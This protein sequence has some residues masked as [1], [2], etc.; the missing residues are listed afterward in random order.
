ML[1][2]PIKKPDAAKMFYDRI[3]LDQR[4]RSETFA[5]LVVQF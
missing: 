3:N 2:L 5:Q 4:I 1:G